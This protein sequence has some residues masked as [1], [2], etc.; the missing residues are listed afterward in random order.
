MI[1]VVKKKEYQRERKHI[2]PRTCTGVFP[3]LK[4]YFLVHIPFSSALAKTDFCHLAYL[5]VLCEKAILTPL[6]HETQLTDC[7][8][9]CL[10][11]AQT[12]SLNTICFN[13][14]VDYFY[15]IR[16]GFYVSLKSSNTSNSYHMSCSAVMICQVFFRTTRDP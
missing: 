6:A 14:A 7:T 2:I 3:N 16:L 15:Y 1:L 5:C 4:N 13:F 10:C 12:E 11:A 9:V 8:G